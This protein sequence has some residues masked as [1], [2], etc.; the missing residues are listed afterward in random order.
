MHGQQNT[1]LVRNTK[2][3]KCVHY[4]YYYYKGIKDVQ[5][6]KWYLL[7]ESHATCKYTLRQSA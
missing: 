6:N 2:Q 5:D 3:I 1:K 4:Y 7:C